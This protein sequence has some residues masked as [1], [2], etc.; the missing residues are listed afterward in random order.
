MKTGTR[1]MGSDLQVVQ[2]NSTEP[3]WQKKD[4]ASAEA[5]I[6][7]A[8]SPILVSAALPPEVEQGMRVIHNQPAIRALLIESLV[9]QIEAGTY[10]IDSRAIAQK[11]LNPDAL[12]GN[13]CEPHEQGNREAGLPRG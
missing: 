3:V 6:A 12:A 5:R 8:A 2:H 10:S 4:R 11:M 7:S 9:A 13:P 1:K